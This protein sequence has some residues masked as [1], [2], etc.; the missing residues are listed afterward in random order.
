MTD[1]PSQPSSAGTINTPRVHEALWRMRYAQELADSPLLATAA[2][3]AALARSGLPDTPADR[4]FALAR[5]LADLLSAALA[6]ARGPGWNAS[7]APD[8]PEGAGAAELA[9]DFAS[10]DAAREALSAVYHRFVATGASPVAELAARAGVSRRSFER[11]LARGAQLLAELLR[12]AEEQAMRASAATAPASDPTAA[13]A[14]AGAPASPPAWAALAGEWRARLA[15]GEGLRDA[16]RA[17]ASEWLHRAPEDLTAYRLARVAQATSARSRLDAVFVPLALA[18]DASATG[19]LSPVDRAPHAS[20]DAFLAHADAPAVVV[21]G[22]PGSGKSTLLQ[23]FELTAAIDGLSGEPAPITLLAPLGAFGASGSDE[24]APAPS[25][26]LARIWARRAPRLAP[27]AEHLAEGGVVLLLDGLD[28]LPRSDRALGDAAIRPWRDWVE[29]LAQTATASGRPNRAV[30][31]CRTLEYT[32]PLSRPHLPVPQAWVEPLADDAAR[33]LVHAYALSDADARLDLLDAASDAERAV[34]RW[35]FYLRLFAE[36]DPSAPAARTGATSLLSD[37]VRRALVRE[38]ERGHPAL[39]SGRLLSAHDRR[40][41]LSASGAAAPH[42]LALEGPLIDRLAALGHALHDRSTGSGGGRGRARRDEVLALLAHDD[43]ADMVAAAEALAV[44]DAD[45]ERDEVHFAHLLL[46]EYFAARWAGRDPAELARRAEAPWRARDVRPT[47]VETLAGLGAT[48]AMPPLPVTGWET[49][50]ELAAAMADAPAE[51]IARLKDGNL[52]LAGRCA[53]MPAIRERLPDDLVA[54]LV[55]DLV[56]RSADVVADLRARI[57]AARA[58]GELGDPRLSAG[59]GP[60][61]TY[62]LGPMVELPGMRFPMGE[63]ASGDGPPASAQESHSPRHDVA[64]GAFAMAAFP[65][66]NVEWR[67]FVRSGGYE[68]PRWWPGAAAQRWW[69]G[70]GT[71]HAVRE[72]VRLWWRRFRERPAML[73]EVRAA[74]QIDDALYDEWHARLAHDEAGLEAYLAERFP[75]G[76][77][78]APR[79]WGEP[80]FDHPSQPVVGICWFEARA[81]AL[82]LAAQTERPFRLP[83]EAEWERAA[84]GAEGRAYPYG[85]ALD[86]VRCNVRAS[87]VRRPTPIGVYPGGA[88]P[89]GITDLTGNVLEWTSSAV[90]AYPYDAEDGRELQDTAPDVQRVLRGGSWINAFLDV[91]AAVRYPY[92]PDA[93][94]AIDGLRVV[95]GSR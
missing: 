71:A 46:Q 42:D 25:D 80:A 6:R 49:V 5:L 27:L 33:R 26:W 17:L 7:G 54:G 32:V 84:R 15:R 73:D 23:R 50:A 8:D 52:P 68:N 45:A 66:T 95:C 34:L 58:L 56:A 79:H 20:L 53:A 74:G 44:L 88:S 4:A 70:E 11:R 67:A 57:A 82:W 24:P 2:V 55:G 16:D 41:I 30:F 51:L 29:E 12:A 3:S 63:P 81:Y 65:V 37:G 92:I 35:P 83:T 28:E 40:R 86:P 36:Q 18:G 19:G 69:Q 64:V 48:D 75:A 13:R 93:R 14:G 78:T 89:E 87:R 1:A 10:G 31:T 59:R 60:D 85:D 72:N 61:G 76:R 38:L 39:A 22:P 94:D 47:L 43:A 91:R 62:L 21:L 77:K 90:R 9:A